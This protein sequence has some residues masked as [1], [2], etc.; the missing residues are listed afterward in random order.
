M[1]SAGESRSKVGAALVYSVALY[2]SFLA[3]GCQEKP[4]TEIIRVYAAASLSDAVREIGSRFEADTGYS[5]EY[6]FAGS[7]TLAQQIVSASRA[8]VFFSAD[9]E[10]MAYVEDRGKIASETR[11]NVIANRL[12]AIGRRQPGGSSTGKFDWCA[13]RNA[14]V[15]IGDPESVPVGKYAKAWLEEIECGEASAWAA[16]SDRLIPSSDARTTLAQTLSLSDAIGIVYYS[17]YV[18]ARDEVELLDES[19]VVVAR[20]EGALTRTGLEKLAAGKFFVF[21]QSD[22][23]GDILRRYGFETVSG[24]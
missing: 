24:N 21:A 9:S 15:C 4:D 23:A 16:V 14:H 7:N 22:V 11:Q 8:D 2:A 19:A 3:T 18:S 13:L 5:V 20:Y 1:K 10:W 17:D 12:V 6:N